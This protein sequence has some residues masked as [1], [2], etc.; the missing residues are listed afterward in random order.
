MKEIPK[1]KLLRRLIWILVSLFVLVALVVVSFD[2]FY[3]YHAPWFGLKAVLNDRDNQMPGT[4]RNFEYDAVL[5]GSSV[6]EN[7]DSTFLDEKFACSTLK[8]IRASGSV[9]DLLYY[10][11][12]AHEVQNLKRV[13]WCLDIFALNSDVEVTLFSEDTPRYLHTKSTLDDLPY[14]FNKEILLE[15]I[16]YM[17]A[18]S[19]QG[20]NT[21]GNAY[22]WSRGKNFSA[23]TAMHVYARDAIAPDAVI[24]QRDIAERE[25]LISQNI[26][27]VLAEVK[28]H[29]DTEYIFL[30]PPYSLLWWDCAYLNGELAERLYILEQVLPKLVEA[31]NA[32][33]YYFQNNAEIVCNLD[34]YMD[35]VHYSP[36]INQYM[37]ECMADGE[38]ALTEENREA[39]LEAMKELTKWISQEEIYKYYPLPE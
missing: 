5:V 14:L 2:P 6:A 29:P 35:M 32:Q 36:A 19:F 25:Q 7:F 15:K 31:E 21:G 1:K 34:N 24:P 39:E 9:A 22:N 17:M 13:F 11:E 23:G 20:M 12:Q 38:C 10:L 16:P 27:M 26:N 18:C 4:I 30:F 8:I 3:Q 33:V 28:A 37:L